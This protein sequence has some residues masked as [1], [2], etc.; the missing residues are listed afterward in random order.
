MAGEEVLLR[1]SFVTIRINCSTELA[2]LEWH[3]LTP[4]ELCQILSTSLAQG[5]SGEQVKRKKEEYGSNVSLAHSRT[6]SKQ[7]T[8]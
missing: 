7:L 3:T 2:D 5:L 4:N 1:F 6:R 8:K